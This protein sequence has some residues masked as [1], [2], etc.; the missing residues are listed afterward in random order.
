MLDIICNP[1]NVFVDG[2]LH[3]VVEGVTLDRIRSIDMERKIGTLSPVSQFVPT[4]RP[5]HILTNPNKSEESL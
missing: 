4:K 3:C 5:A 1:G 2:F